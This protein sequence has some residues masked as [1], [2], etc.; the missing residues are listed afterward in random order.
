METAEQKRARRMNDDTIADADSSNIAALTCEVSDEAV[1]AAAAP[2]AGPGA[3]S[4]FN[5]TSFH[6][7]CC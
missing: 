6:L 7:A 3:A 5:F 4:S 1:E 2:P